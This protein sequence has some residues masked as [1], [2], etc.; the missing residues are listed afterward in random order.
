M[1]KRSVR[2]IVIA[3]FALIFFAG[4]SLVR[5]YTDWLWFGEVGYQFVFATMLRSQGTLFTI[6]FGVTLVWLAL[7]LRLA[8][9]S[10]G[11][12]RPVFTT[13]E[14]LQ[15]ALPNRRQLATLAT[16]V[17]AVVAILVGL[18]AAGR[19]NLWLAWRNAVP[20]GEDDPLLGRDVSFFIFTLPFLQFVRG[21]MQGLVILAAIGSGAV[22][23]VSGSM[24][25][26]FPA[27][28]GMTSAARR[29]LSLLGAVFLLL[30]AFGA[31]LHRAEYLI[32]AGGTIAGASYADVYARMPITFLLMA[33]CVVGAALAV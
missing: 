26:S 6:A 25:S 11:E 27:S 9:A 12:L 29:H 17:A 28:F 8:V 10:I 3:L 14:G 4:P 2:V 23:F 30:L 13:R 33:V 24:S 21:L 32:P 20:F 1:P 16:V 19:W 18:F 22:Y 7:N 31:W 15:V 5:F